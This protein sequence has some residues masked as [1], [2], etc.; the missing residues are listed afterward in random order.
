MNHLAHC[1]LSSDDE[2]ILVGNFIGDDVKGSAWQAYPEGI[3]KGILRHRTIDSFT[4]NHPMAGRSKERIRSFAGRYAAAVTDILYD[5]LLAIHWKKYTDEPFDLFA[6]KVY[7]RLEK[8]AEE[9]PAV[10]Q[11]R[12]PLML[13]GRFLHGYQSREGL[14]WVLDR[15]SRRVRNDIFQKSIHSGDFSKH[16]FA[17]IDLFSADFNAFFPDLLEIVAKN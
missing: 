4:D 6:E 16:F 10:L 7:N 11:H 13:A 3:Q 14:E 15:F 2:D 5:H 8:R 1:F 9:M 12:L 17:Q